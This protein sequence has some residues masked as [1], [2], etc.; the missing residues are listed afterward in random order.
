M[1]LC[2]GRSP[3]FPRLL[4]SL[5]LC[6]VWMKGPGRGSRG[7]WDQG[8][9]LQR[10]S[11][12]PCPEWLHSEL[13]CASFCPP[14]QLGP[15]CSN[16]LLWWLLV[17]SDALDV[18]GE[19]WDE[20]GWDGLRWDGLQHFGRCGPV[21]PCGVPGEVLTGWWLCHPRQMW[22]SRTWHPRDRGSCLGC[23][24]SSPGASWRDEHRVSQPD[25]ALL[26]LRAGRK[27]RLPKQTH[28]TE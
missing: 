24:C 16:P 4:I 17:S 6:V 23:C 13:G 26:L 18:F 22:P 25:P 12:H 9:G 5:S 3:P 1:E 15:S 11:E 19:G 10:G 21:C 14:N 2:L 8:F 27:R 28:G 20:V 7:M